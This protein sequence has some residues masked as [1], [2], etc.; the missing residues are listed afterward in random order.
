MSV[1]NARNAGRKPSIN[2]LELEI[3]KT[4]RE[5]GAPVTQLAEEYGVS[6]QTMSAY[7]NRNETNDYNELIYKTYKK[8]VEINRDF[9]KSFRMQDYLLRMEFMCEDELCSSILVNFK[10]KE[11]NEVVLS[12]FF[13]KWSCLKPRNINVMYKCCNTAVFSVN[14][15]EISEAN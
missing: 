10:D 6:R 14:R 1:W 9:R 7:L 8:W 2:D 5:N 3:I 13:L 12:F 11:I 15:G 4:K